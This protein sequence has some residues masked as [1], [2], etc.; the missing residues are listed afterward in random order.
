MQKY[1]NF[2][3]SACLYGQKIISLSIPLVSKNCRQNLDQKKSS[4]QALEKKLLKIHFRT[5][6]FKADVHK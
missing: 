6:T 5:T 2:N 3:F 1:K 4:W